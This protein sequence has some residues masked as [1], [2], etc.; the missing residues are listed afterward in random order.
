MKFTTILVG[1]LSLATGISA[2]PS[3]ADVDQAKASK[4]ISELGKVYQANVLQTVKSN[5]KT[6][7]TPDKLIRRKEWGSMAKKEQ[8]S[9]VNAVICLSKT[10][11]RTSLDVAPGARSRYD[12]FIVLHHLKTPF[13]HGNGRFLGFH[14]AFVHL[15]ETALREECGYTGGQPYWDWTKSYKDPR[16]ASIFDGSP[17]SLSGNGKYVPN[18]APIT[19]YIGKG[20]FLDRLP[21]TGGGCV[22]SGPFTADKFTINLG[23][24]GYNATEDPSVPGDGLGYN[25]RCLKRDFSTYYSQFSRP[26]NVTHVLDAADLEEFNANMDHPVRGI[27]GTGHFQVGGIMYDTFASPSDPAFFAHHAQL[28]RIWAIWQG[29]NASARTNQLWGTLTAG[30]EP[31]SADVTADTPV[32]LGVLHADYKL[33]EILSTIDGPHCYIYE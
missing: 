32:E 31:P 19:S 18:R 7:C 16:T 6:K 11:A 15:Y 14:R 27:H 26:T 25:P 4:Y 2:A 21:G 8:L 13:V 33:G 23:P 30:N 12:D 22:E 10:P 3:P 5:P 17:Y 20:L 28:D 1:S 24:F 29:Q 9:Y